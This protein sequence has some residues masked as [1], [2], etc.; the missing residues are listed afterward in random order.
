MF[1]FSNS[2]MQYAVLNGIGNVIPFLK[3]GEVSKVYVFGAYIF[4]YSMEPFV[5]TY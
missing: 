5:K 2:F 1:L 3:P 4:L